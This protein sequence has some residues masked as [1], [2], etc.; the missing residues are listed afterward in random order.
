VAIRGHGQHREVPESRRRNERG[1]AVNWVCA[2]CGFVVDPDE[3]GRV[4]QVGLRGPAPSRA[5][6]WGPV[7]IHADCIGYLP[8][9]VGPLWNAPHH[10]VATER[11]L[12]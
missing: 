3:D 6:A 12:A 7:V 11:I 9:R 2:L 5:W 8:Q 4:L 10:Q 1:R